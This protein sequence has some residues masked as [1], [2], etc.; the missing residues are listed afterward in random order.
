MTIRQ[1]NSLYIDTYGAD[2][3]AIA[4]GFHWLCQAATRQ[5]NL[6]GTIAVLV[7]GHLNYVIQDTLGE[8]IT[9]PLA[10][11][12]KVELTY[13]SSTGETEIELSLL[14]LRMRSIGLISGPVLAFY[15]NKLMLDMIDDMGSV[16]DVLVI[17]WRPVSESKAMTGSPPLSIDE[18]VK[19]W[20]DTWQ[21][22]ILGAPTQDVSPPPFYDPVVENA[23]KDLT[24][25]VNLTTGIAHPGDERVA[26]A[27][28]KLL[29]NEGYTLNSEA[30]RAWL[31][32]N[33]WWSR[34]ADAVCTLVQKI[35]Q[36]R[37][38][39]SRAVRNVQPYDKRM[40]DLWKNREDDEE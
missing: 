36:N 35:V 37:R 26:I 14:F 22:Q 28:F 1:R 3:D 18:D 39:G 31:I 25:S 11:N 9:R 38:V 29:H 5:E 27:T 4:R 19:G 13:P 30:I 32:R 34:H 12:K 23:L 16:S 7:L 21:A 17:P 20:I 8:D 33:N 24:Q 6:S 15:P 2:E 40:L 10:K